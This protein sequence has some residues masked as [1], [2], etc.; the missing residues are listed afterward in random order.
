M[1][2]D[3]AAVR[4]VAVGIGQLVVS[5]DPND[6]LVAYGLGSCVAVGMYDAATHI[7]G[8]VHVLL[9]RSNEPQRSTEEP[10]RYADTAIDLLLKRI[11]RRG[12]LQARLVVKLAGGASVLGVQ[13]AQKFKIGERNAEAIRERLRHHGLGIS[14]EATGGTKG[15]TF[16]LH[17][18]NGQCFVRTAAST[19]SEL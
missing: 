18:A 19:T 10:G 12:A 8:M 2:A 4:R 6:V 14:A 15:R 9:P 16:E 1:S 13:N 7:G 5:S 17:L 3:T 11:T